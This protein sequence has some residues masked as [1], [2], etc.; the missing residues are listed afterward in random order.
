M[1]ITE[2]LNDFLLACEADGLAPSTV[3][4]YQSLL[5]PFA[6]SHGSEPVSS[7]TSRDMRE[8]IVALRET[9][10]KYSGAPQKPEQQGGYSRET[11]KG[12]V[13]AS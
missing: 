2:A 9:T 11:I 3:K 8:Y 1:T 5:K 7:I 12:H 6:A 10:A 4:W 13:T